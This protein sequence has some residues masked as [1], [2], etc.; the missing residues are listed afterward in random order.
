MDGGISMNCYKADI[1]FDEPLP[2]DKNEYDKDYI[3]NYAIDN[4]SET[5]ICNK[6]S[7]IYR[8]IERKNN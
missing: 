1:I 4:F 7:D 3:S 8:G 2:M 6:L 5:S